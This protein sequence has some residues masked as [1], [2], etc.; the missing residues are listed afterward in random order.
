MRRTSAIALAVLSLS[1]CG[2]ET[3]IE[4]EVIGNNPN[5]VPTVIDTLSVT[6]RKNNEV[7]FPKDARDKADFK[8]TA[9][10]PQTIAIVGGD[11]VR[12][13]KVTILVT[14]KRNNVYQMSK[15]RDVKLEP[16]KTVKLQV[17]LP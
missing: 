5:M 6:V 4:L 13:G 15:E 1:A 8:L 11:Q 9:Q 10:L 14:G 17:A 16:G 3:V 2:A 12:D 7:V